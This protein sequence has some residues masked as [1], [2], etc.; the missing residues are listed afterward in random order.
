MANVA[1]FILVVLR[2]RCLMDEALL[3]D[4]RG[5]AQ[6]PALPPALSLPHI[7]SAR[8]GTSST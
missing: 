2:Q 8:E 7:P 5:L 6:L 1:L 3:Q 4:F